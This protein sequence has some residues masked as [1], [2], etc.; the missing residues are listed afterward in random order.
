MIE[1]LKWANTNMK[2]NICEYRANEKVRVIVS[3]FIIRPHFTKHV[4]PLHPALKYNSPKK[5]Q[6]LF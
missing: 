4:L 1:P 2:K 5:A 3:K 6:C